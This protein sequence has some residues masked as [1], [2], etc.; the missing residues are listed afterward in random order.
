MNWEEDVDLL[1]G[2]KASLFF[3]YFS[4]WARCLQS[5]TKHGRRASNAPGTPEEVADSSGAKS[6]PEVPIRARK[7]GGW[8]DEGTKSA[9][10]NRRVAFT[11]FKC[12]VLGRKAPTWLNSKYLHLKW[13]LC[14]R[15]ETGRDFTMIR[16]MSR[17]MTFLWYQI[18]M[19]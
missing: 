9:K 15:V 19:I 11:V 2:K 14:C 17:M 8:A 1:P 7:T 13:V 18:L 6:P 3:A 12:W 16:H 5:A 10:Y 4:V